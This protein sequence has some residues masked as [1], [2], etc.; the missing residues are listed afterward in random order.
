MKI[1]KGRGDRKEPERNE[2]GPYTGAAPS[3]NIDRSRLALVWSLLTVCPSQ[4]H[5]K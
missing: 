5:E 1:K 4:T 3:R 2:S